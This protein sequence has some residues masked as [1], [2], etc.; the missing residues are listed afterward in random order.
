VAG[1]RRAGARAE[2]FFEPDLVLPASDRLGGGGEALL[3]VEDGPDWT[4]CLPVQAVRWHGWRVPVL[5]SWRH[6]YCFL[7]TP[8]LDPEAPLAALGRVLDQALPR[9]RAGMLALDAVGWDGGFADALETAM[10][11]RGRVMET[12]R[13]RERATLVRREEAGYHE[14]MRAHHRRELRRLR[15]GLERLVGAVPTTREVSSDP[16]ASERFLAL[17]RAGWKGRAGTA[18]ASSP[19]HAEFFRTVCERFADAGRLEL[20]AFRGRGPHACREVQPA[21]RRSG[22]LLQDRLRRGVRQVLARY[23][24]RGRASR[25]RPEAQASR[26]AGVLQRVRHGGSTLLRP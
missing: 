26:A 3:I 4:A 23:S 13:S 15:R 1:P 25:A 5:M 7:G 11:E 24:A 21:R 9:A 12:Y 14:G 18:F 17:E 19:R 6:S 22:V 20:L 2:P 10:T 16:V 8:L